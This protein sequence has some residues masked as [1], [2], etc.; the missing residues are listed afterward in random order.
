[1]TVKLP[2]ETPVRMQELEATRIP[3][4]STHTC[5]KDVNPRDRLPLPP[6][7][8]PLLETESTPGP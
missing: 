6:Y 8:Y 1:M 3:R 4:L 7:I 5:G 2:L